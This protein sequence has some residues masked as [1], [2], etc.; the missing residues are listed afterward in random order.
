[1]AILNMIIY[2]KYEL[3]TRIDNMEKNI[4]KILNSTRN[5]VTGAG[6]SPS[7]SCTAMV[8]VESRRMD[9]LGKAGANGQAEKAPSSLPPRAEP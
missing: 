2:T 1:M 6:P 8:A 3:T 5:E 7:E 4:K 9:G